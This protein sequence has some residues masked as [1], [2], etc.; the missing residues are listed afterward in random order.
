M[1]NFGMD[2]RIKL[3]TERMGITYPIWHDPNDAFTRTFKAIGV[4][5]S[6][7]IDKN[8]TIYHHWKG[9]FNPMADST[10]SIVEDALMEVSPAFAST[11]TLSNSSLSAST[12]T[13]TANQDSNSEYQNRQ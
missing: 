8:G 9:Q 1:D 10:K 4:P 11:D 2:D 12:T 3:F 6:Y 7:L 5:E 13:T